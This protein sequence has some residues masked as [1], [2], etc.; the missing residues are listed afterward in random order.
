MHPGAKP[1]L[2]V[3]VS[4]QADEELIY[5]AQSRAA[6]WRL[7]FVPRGRKEP[8]GP[9]LRAAADALLVF[10]REGVSLWD[11]HGHFSF[12]P[13]M[14]HLRCQRVRSGE[15]DTLVKMAGLHRGEHVLDCTLGL[16]QDALVAAVAVGP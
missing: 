6:Q 12:H 5:Q 16:A 2:A 7:P 11:E 8:L 15:G 14:A 3:T 4:G 9:M 13:G 1:P 10:E